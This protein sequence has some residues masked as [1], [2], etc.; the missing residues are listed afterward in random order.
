M[1]NGG[2]LRARD[3][4]LVVTDLEGSGAEHL[5]EKENFL[6]GVEVDDEVVDGERGKMF[7]RGEEISIFDVDVS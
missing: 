2:H 5:Q 4:V 1:L 7:E 3:G 6:H